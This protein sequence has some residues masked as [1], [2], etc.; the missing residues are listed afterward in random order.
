MPDPGD[1]R[2][3]FRAG[4]YLWGHWRWECAII[5][6]LVVAALIAAFEALA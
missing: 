4:D 6:A 2:G 1:Y 3:H 5:A